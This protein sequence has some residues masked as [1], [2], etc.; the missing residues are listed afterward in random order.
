[1]LKHIAIIMDG[2]GRWAKKRLLPRKAGHVS[3][4][5]A[6]K[7]VVKLALQHNVQTLTLFALSIENFLCR[8]SEEVESLENLFASQLKERLDSLNK[9]GI[10]LIFIG[11]RQQLN[12]QLID[13]MSHSEAITANNKAL[14]LCIAVNYSGRWDMMN[15]TKQAIDYCIDNQ[16]G[17]TTI[18][19][20]F[21][22]QFLS[23]AEYPEPD[24][25]IRTGGDLRISNFLLWQLAYTELYFTETLWPDFNEVLFDSAVDSFNARKRN[26]GAIDQ[27]A[28]ETYA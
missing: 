1:M 28:G 18:D 17:S 6:V 13:L 16:K 8:S 23:L 27:P 19:E 12:N 26:F 20:K 15:A 21:I 9:Q 25:L 4:V 22:G 7:R 10:K 5:K 3:G 2:N 24:L 11:D 14:T